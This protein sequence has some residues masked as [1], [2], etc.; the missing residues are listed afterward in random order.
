MRTNLPF[1]SYYNFQRDG[2]LFAIGHCACFS[3]NSRH[4]QPPVGEVIVMADGVTRGR[5]DT[6][7]NSRSKGS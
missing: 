1:I 6:N 2:T 7:P 3:L 5:A 4:S